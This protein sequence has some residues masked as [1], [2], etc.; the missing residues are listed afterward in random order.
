MSVLNLY[1][2]FIKIMRCD[3]CSI[4]RNTDFTTEIEGIEKFYYETYQ[5]CSVCLEYL[6]RR[7]DKF[8]ESRLKNWENQKK[9][10]A[11]TI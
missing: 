6:Q 11:R 4:I 10:N 9:N 1:T 8:L 5:M 7:D 2:H 3:K